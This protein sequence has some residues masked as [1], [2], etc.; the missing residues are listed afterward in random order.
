M[1]DDLKLLGLTWKIEANRIDGAQVELCV[2]RLPRPNLGGARDLVSIAEVGFGLS[3]TVPLVVALLAA[4]PPA[5]SRRATRPSIWIVAIASP[6]GANANARK[7]ASP[8]PRARLVGVALR[9]GPRIGSQVRT[10]TPSTSRAI[11]LPFHR[12][13]GELPSRHALRPSSA[14]PGIGPG[15]AAARRGGDSLGN[16][17]GPGRRGTICPW[18]GPPDLPMTVLFSR[19]ACRGKIE[20]VIAHPTRLS[21]WARGL[22]ARRMPVRWVA[23]LTARAYGPPLIDGESFVSFHAPRRRRGHHPG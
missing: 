3:Q 20:A 7:G 2:G 14:V 1:S 12:A 13:I 15:S 16:P 9:G 23:C 22:V 4:L 21:R 19:K 11:R 8:T 6:P 18:G 17:S 10:M 5:A